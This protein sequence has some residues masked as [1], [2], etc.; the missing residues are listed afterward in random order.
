[1]EHKVVSAERWASYV[2][3]FGE[4]GLEVYGGMVGVDVEEPSAAANDGG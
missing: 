3:M 2:S 4:N 1:M